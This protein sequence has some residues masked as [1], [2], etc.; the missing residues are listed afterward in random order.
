MHIEKRGCRHNY[1][2]FS[3]RKPD[4]PLPF[5]QHPHLPEVL[6]FVVSKNV[7]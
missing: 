4:A 5:A 7:G 3:F 1:S 6:V 2:V